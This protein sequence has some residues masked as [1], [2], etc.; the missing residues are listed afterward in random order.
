MELDDVWFKP[1]DDLPQH[2]KIRQRD[3][4]PGNGHQSSNTIHLNAVNLTYTIEMP[5]IKANHSHLMA[6]R[7]VCQIFAN[8]LHP[9]YIRIIILRDM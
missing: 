8:I 5:F 3:G 9:S 4:L 6:G 1:L 2:G 7:V